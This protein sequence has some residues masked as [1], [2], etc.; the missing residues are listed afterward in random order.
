MI[1]Q[2]CLI[3][4][5]LSPEL[6]VTLAVWVFA[7]ACAVLR[8]ATSTTT[9]SRVIGTVRLAIRLPKNPISA[10]YHCLAVDARICVLPNNGRAI[11]PT[12]GGFGAPNLAD[13][14]GLRRQ[15]PPGNQRPVPIA[16]AGTDHAARYA[17]V[18]RDV[19]RVTH[20]GFGRSGRL[21]RVAAADAH[22]HNDECDDGER[23][24]RQPGPDEFGCPARRPDGDEVLHVCGHCL[25]YTSD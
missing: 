3:A 12:G 7:P 1:N 16:S 25:L 5:G 20:A 11:R 21:C 18:R 15:G 13:G 19:A 2:T 14:T 8:P 10:V 9:H 24:D 23:R 22:L 6:V 4:P 17:V